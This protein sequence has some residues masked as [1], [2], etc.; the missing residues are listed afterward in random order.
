[1]T[2]P[3]EALLLVTAWGTMVG[4]DLV[5]VPQ[6]LFA[7]PVVAGF[8][9]GVMLGEPVVGLQVGLILEL[10]AFDTLAIGSARYPDLGSATI[11]AV[12][13]AALLGPGDG[14]IGLGVALGLVLG[15]I[16]G[17]SLE[18]LRRW[19]G[20]TIQQVESM[21]Q[22]GAP[23]LLG[24]LQWMGVGRDALRSAILV[25]VGLGLAGT[26]PGLPPV[27][28][29]APEITWVAIAG[30]GLAGSIGLLRGVARGSHWR[31]FVLGTGAGLL[32]T[33]GLG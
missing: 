18:A 9:A 27:I 8:I 32:L 15:Q 31:W 19:N 11:P 2:L 7:R 1:M 21:L 22:D 16:G 13:A 29:A 14:S 25:V 33:G 10:F 24:R 28:I 3:W 17:V 4:V 20:R 30:S 26:M 6:A 12:V 23:R 5:S